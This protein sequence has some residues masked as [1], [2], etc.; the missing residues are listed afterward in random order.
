MY[1]LQPKMEN[2]MAV[3]KFSLPSCSNNQILFKCNIVNK[4]TLIMNHSFSNIDFLELLHFWTQ[5]QGLCL[6]Y[7][8][9]IQVQGHKNDNNDN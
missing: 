2:P 6:R 8:N 5:K 3:V 7:I 4:E 1:P 9:F